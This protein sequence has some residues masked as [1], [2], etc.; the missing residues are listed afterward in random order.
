MK[1][2]PATQIPEIPDFGRPEYEELIGGL[3]NGMCI[4]VGAG[5][6]KLAGYRL[7]KELAKDL[8]E[9]F[10]KKETIIHSEMESLN[11]SADEEPIKVIDFLFSV[12]K[13]FFH[14][15]LA[16]I[17]ENDKKS[18]KREVYVTLRRFAQV[19]E[20][21]FIQ[22]NIDTG[23]QRSL[24]IRDSDVQIN[25]SLMVPPKRLSYLHGRI[26]RKSSWVLTTRQ[27]D[28]DYLKNGNSTMKFL[29]DIFKSYRV[30]FIGYSLRDP[31][32]QF[33]LRKARL[34]GSIKGHYL[35]EAFN[36]N[37]TTDMVIQATNFREN[38][39]IELIPYNIEKKGYEL[40]MN[41]LNE[42]NKMLSYRKIR[43]S[44]NA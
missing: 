39:N 25:P 35:L 16:E 19:A 26:D 41:V 27:Y 5:V 40:L 21:L 34:D 30:L 32:I 4:F 9:E 44:E 31:E 12:N 14:A 20:N 3:Q 6:S 36:V 42:L 18:E 2:K 7:W 29:I 8:V 37:R 10:W 22:T 23:L 43:S 13:D 1:L 33:A 28:R 24:G 38:F 15:K 17:F 11:K